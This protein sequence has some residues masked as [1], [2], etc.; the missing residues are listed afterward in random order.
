[1][2]APVFLFQLLKA[3]LLQQQPVVDNANIIR[4]LFDFGQDM[5][6]NQDGFALPVAQL[7]Q[8]GARPGDADGVKAVG[9]LV[10]NQQFRAVQDGKGDCKPLL[11]PQRILGVQLAVAVGQADD[12]KRVFN[13]VPVL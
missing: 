8:E 13:G 3:F 9:R 12:I 1:M 6:G 11:H 5:A 7:P 10:R 2:I 4:E